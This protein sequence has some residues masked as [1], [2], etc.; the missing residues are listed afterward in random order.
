MSVCISN[1]CLCLSG[2]KYVWDP[3][4]G[5]LGSLLLI[6]WCSHLESASGSPDAY[7]EGMPWDSVLDSLESVFISL[8][9]RLWE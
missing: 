9:V 4:I 1:G 7:V 3:C 5:V 2:S 6:L 8:L